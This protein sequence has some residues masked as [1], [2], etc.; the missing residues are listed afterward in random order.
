VRKPVLKPA[1]KPRGLWGLALPLFVGA[2]V[3]MGYYVYWRHVADRIETQIRAALP[4]DSMSSVTV[5][6]F[7][8]RLTA[9]ITDLTLTNGNGA[10]FRAQKLEATATPLN[11]LL[12]VLD[13]ATAPTLQLGDGV[14][15]PLQAKNLRASLRLKSEG[16]ER[17]S[18][19]CD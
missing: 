1:G 5:N 11:P 10:R 3:V 7:P 14:K 8:Y 6:G 2:A 17:F 15:W 18:L 9:Q 12:W 13:G 4:A 16:L 19:T